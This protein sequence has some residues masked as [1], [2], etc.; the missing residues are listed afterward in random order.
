MG[1]EAITGQHRIAG[2][3]SKQLELPEKAWMEIITKQFAKKML[4]KNVKA[5][6]AG[7]TLTV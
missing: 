7:R 5:F 6:E 4:D 1:S 3:L 2:V